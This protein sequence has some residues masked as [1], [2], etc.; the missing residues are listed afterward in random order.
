M[1]AHAPL[2][3]VGLHAIAGNDVMRW[4]SAAWC[5]RSRSYAV[6]SGLHAAR[7]RTSRAGTCRCLVG[8]HVDTLLTRSHGHRQLALPRSDVHAGIKPLAARHTFTC[9]W[10]P[11]QPAPCRSNRHLVAAAQLR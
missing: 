4:A 8:G 2:H 7:V 10:M 6:A 5:Q 3:C 9:A 1:S 11:K